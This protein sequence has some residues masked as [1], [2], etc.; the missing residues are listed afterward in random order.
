MNVSPIFTLPT[1][2]PQVVVELQN[3][4]EYFLDD[5]PQRCR[6]LIEKAPE[7]YNQKRVQKTPSSTHKNRMCLM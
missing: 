1:P 5:F 4:H 7:K 2:R 6:L 3:D